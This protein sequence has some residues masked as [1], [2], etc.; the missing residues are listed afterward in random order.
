[1]QVLVTPTK[2]EEDVVQDPLK[3]QGEACLVGKDMQRPRAGFR[4]ECWAF[5]QHTFEKLEHVPYESLGWL[6]QQS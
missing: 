2:I 4:T 6:G 1:M 5:R 3:A